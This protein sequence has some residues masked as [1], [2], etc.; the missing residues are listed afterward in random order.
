VPLGRSDA[1]RRE[2]YRIVAGDEMKQGYARYCDEDEMV[3]E[4]EERERVKE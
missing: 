1:D 4:G 2:R 3:G